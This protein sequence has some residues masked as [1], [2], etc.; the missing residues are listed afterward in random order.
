MTDTQPHQILPAPGKQAE[1]GPVCLVTGGA[2]YVGGVIIRRLLDQGYKVHS[3]DLKP[4]AIDDDN[5][6]SFTGDIR[7]YEDVAK[8]C[9][10]VNTIFH[11]AAVISL[12]GWARSKVRNLVMDINVAG[13]AQLIKVAQHQGVER[14]IYTSTNNVCFDREIINGDETMPYA[15]RPADLYTETKGMAEKLV[16][17]ADN[18]KTGL[19]TSAVRPGGIW[20]GTE[21]GIMI[22]SFLD[23]VANGSFMAL[24]GN[25]KSRADNTHVDNL[26]DAQILCAEKLVTDATRVGGEAYYIMDEEPTS[27]IDW[28]E[29]LM[30]EI[31]EKWPKIRIPGPIMFGLGIIVE[32][33]IYWGAPELPFS[34]AGMHKLLRTH[35]FNC[36]KAHR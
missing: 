19:R 22:T 20:G 3:F 8:A 25:G 10:G 17:E 5:I 34:R 30:E 2:G 26:V 21:G 35:T 31:G 16:L 24:P 9:E 14:L 33:L 28:F 11:T 27:T 6:T 29:P 18:G 1:I 15:T 12:L 23:Q 4:C 36:D 32:A 13:T 7:K